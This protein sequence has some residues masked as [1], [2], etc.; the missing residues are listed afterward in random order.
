MSLYYLHMIICENA[1]HI[2][3]PCR[4]GGLYVAHGPQ[5]MCSVAL[6]QTNLNQRWTNYSLS[7]SDLGWFGKGPQNTFLLL[8]RKEKQTGQTLLLVYCQLVHEGCKSHQIYHHCQSMYLWLI[9]LA[10]YYVGHMLFHSQMKWILLQH[11]AS[12]SYSALTIIVI[13]SRS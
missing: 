12:Y 13:T 3:R 11:N 6:F 5:K 4:P 10:H 9:Q 8:E 2:N 1:G 7:I